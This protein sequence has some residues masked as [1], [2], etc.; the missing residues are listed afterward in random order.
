L[1]NALRICVV[2]WFFVP[3]EITLKL[4]F[5]FHFFVNDLFC[6]LAFV[7]VAV[8]F[9]HLLTHSEYL[10]AEACSES[11]RNVGDH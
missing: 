3:F 6:E 10:P 2:V 1:A 5:H 8:S 9:I 4:L 7:S 11:R